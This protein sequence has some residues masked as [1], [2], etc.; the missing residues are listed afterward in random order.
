MRPAVAACRRGR[1][2][3]TRTSPTAVAVAARR[4]TTAAASRGTAAEPA[5]LRFIGQGRRLRYAV[6]SLPP[7]PNRR[8]SRI[9]RNREGWKTTGRRIS[10]YRRVS[11]GTWH[12]LPVAAVVLQT[13]EQRL[14]GAKSR[15][16]RRQI[17]DAG[18][19]AAAMD[20]HHP[21]VCRV[22]LWSP[23]VLQAS[24]HQLLRD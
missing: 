22:R 15:Q 7:P 1:P 4:S 23:A 9:S 16:Q 2:T 14:A 20:P 13:A 10:G 21:R 18:T 24:V 3:H 8:A 19:A 12:Q 6:E 5:E 11:E 17:A